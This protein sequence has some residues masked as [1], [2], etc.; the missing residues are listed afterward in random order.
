M[1]KK[2]EFIKSLSEDKKVILLQHFNGL[3]KKKLKKLSK[4]E[5]KILY[6]AWMWKNGIVTKGPDD[7][8][9][10]FNEEAAGIPLSEYEDIHYWEGT[11]EPDSN[12]LESIH[13]Q[14]DLDRL[15]KIL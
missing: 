2:D 5:N 11:Y 10:T 6:L 14:Y 1:N 4:D 7:K 3:R 9:H 13:M 15:I 12:H 8:F